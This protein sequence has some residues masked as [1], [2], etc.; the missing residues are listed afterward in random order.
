MN[1][2]VEPATSTDISWI[3][4][5]EAKVFSKDDAV[6]EQILRDW[7]NQSPNGFSTVKRDGQRIGHVNLLPLNDSVFSKFVS[8]LITERQIRG[9]ELHSPGERGLVT[10]IYVESLVI[11]PPSGYAAAPAARYLLLNGMSLIDRIG[12]PERIE[13]VIAVAATNQGQRLLRALGF[14]VVSYAKDRKDRHDLYAAPFAVL[15][16]EMPRRF[17]FPKTE[18]ALAEV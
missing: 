3:A 16:D 15:Q 6:P 5:F 4:G 1:Y 9:S 12:D 7:Y 18:R 8:G 10:N 2:K 11:I 13:S 17:R 14:G